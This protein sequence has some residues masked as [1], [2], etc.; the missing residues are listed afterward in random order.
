MFAVHKFPTNLF[1]LFSSNSCTTRE[2][3]SSQQRQKKRIFFLLCLGR[4]YLLFRIIFTEHNK[5]KAKCTNCCCSGGIFSAHPEPCISGALCLSSKSEPHR[6]LLLFTHHCYFITTIF[7]ERRK[8][9]LN[10]FL[11]VVLLFKQGLLNFFKLI[12]HHRQIHHYLNQPCSEN[13][14]GGSFRGQGK[15]SI[16]RCFTSSTWWAPDPYLS[17]LSKDKHD[18]VNTSPPPPAERT[19]SPTNLYIF[20]LS[21]PQILILPLIPAYLATQYPSN[22]VFIQQSPGQAPAHSSPALAF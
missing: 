5:D 8:K 11:H 17:R 19:S 14:D 18:A 13:T 6:R 3:F 22:P 4:A 1:Q 7:S 10:D 21:T 16:I 20:H 2:K 9:N 15:R 12:T